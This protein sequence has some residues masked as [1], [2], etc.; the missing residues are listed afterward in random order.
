[1]IAALHGAQKVVGIDVNKKAIDCAKKLIKKQNLKNTLV[2][3]SGVNSFLKSFSGYFDIMISGAPWDSTQLKFDNDALERAFYDVNDE[4][5]TSILS[6]SRVLFKDKN[7][8]Q[9]FITSSQR[10]LGRVEKLCL[11]NQ[12][13]FEIVKS[14]ELEL[15]NPHYILKL[16]K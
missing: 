1:M 10:A 8:G 15:G 13:Q 7:K 16:F 4:L 6:N 5:L 3:Q 14:A 2:L 9:T 12:M 11:Q